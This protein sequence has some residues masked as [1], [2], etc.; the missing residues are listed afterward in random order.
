ML[1]RVAPISFIAS[2][3]LGPVD[4]GA[5]S[6]VTSSAPLQKR[7]LHLFIGGGKLKCDQSAD[8]EDNG[9]LEV[10]DAIYLLNYLFLHGEAPKSPFGTCGP[11]P[12][13]GQ[14]PLA[15]DSYPPCGTP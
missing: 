5:H 9:A 1:A 4:L 12:A 7:I 3:V 6:K 10:A 2:T 8:L 13:P 11:D 15:C 14:D